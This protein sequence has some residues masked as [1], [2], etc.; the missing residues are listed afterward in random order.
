MTQIGTNVNW[1]FSTHPEV[2]RTDN[3]S[4]RTD[5]VRWSTDLP[6]T[7]FFRELRAEEERSKE[8]PIKKHLITFDLRQL[9]GNKKPTQT[10]FY[11]MIV[12]IKS[13]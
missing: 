10:I 12:I 4:R 5:R 2:K 9:K 8:I 6:T 3:R 1:A 13:V 11:G 7:P